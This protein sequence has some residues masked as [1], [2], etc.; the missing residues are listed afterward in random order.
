M[1]PSRVGGNVG[2]NQSDLAST[3]NDAVPSTADPLHRPARSVP[4]PRL[5]GLERL[6]G[7]QSL[8]RGNG[9]VAD[10][11][12]TLPPLLK[13]RSAT[14]SAP[15]RPGFTSMP[16]SDAGVN[17]S[18][19]PGPAFVHQ[20]GGQTG[21]PL[22]L[23]SAEIKKIKSTH[24]GDQTLAYIADHWQ[25]LMQPPCRLSRTDIVKIAGRGGGARALQAL[26]ALHDELRALGY[27]QADMVR[28]A[29]NHGGAQ[30]LQKVR[31]LHGELGARGYTRSD[32]VRMARHNG[33][34][35]AL[36]KV[37]ALHG[38]LEELGYTR[39][40]IVRMAGHIGGSL[41]LQKVLALHGSL[42]RL[43]Y[44][45]DA[46]VTLASQHRGAARV[47]ERACQT[48]V[49]V[50]RWS[51]AEDGQAVVSEHVGSSAYQPEDTQRTT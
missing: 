8:I 29:A 18:H 12:R 40:D 16:V 7:P 17:P 35:Q 43:G 46:I 21:N 11:P 42:R 26:D 3:P 22:N 1:W 24:G 14:P 28:I 4:D 9:A 6:P 49:R 44:T 50:R 48:A 20:S 25:I 15:S 51:I 39:S 10:A 13:P 19:T 33:G 41:A 23:S 2:P 45:K 47:L 30:A 38:E 31:E 32:I 37:N 34:S 5:Q 36:Q 27:T